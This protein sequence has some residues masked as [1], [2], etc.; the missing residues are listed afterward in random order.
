MRPIRVKP[1]LHLAGLRVRR[2]AAAEPEND[3]Y[4]ATASPRS[5]AANAE[6]C[7]RQ[8][9]AGYRLLPFSSRKDAESAKKTHRQPLNHQLSI[10]HHQSKGYRLPPSC[11]SLPKKCRTRSILPMVA[12]CKGT[13]MISPI[14]AVGQADL[15]EIL[16]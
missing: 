1:L 16:R 14:P 5:A 8:P 12:T 4:P 6:N 9:A 13:W 10:I 3:E 7:N 11:R 2:P 15:Q